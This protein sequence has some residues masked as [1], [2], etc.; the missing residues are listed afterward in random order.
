M[1]KVL[2]EIIVRP[3]SKTLGLRKTVD[4]LEFLTPEPAKSGRANASLLKYLKRELKADEVRIVKGVRDRK[5][6]V[7]LLGEG[8]GKRLASKLKR[9]G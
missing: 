6:V 2:L 5:K 7:V 3:S 9:E 8:I 1:E 4:G